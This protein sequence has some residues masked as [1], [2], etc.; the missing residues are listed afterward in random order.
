ML[1]SRRRHQLTKSIPCHGTMFH[2]REGNLAKEYLVE[3]GNEASISWGSP[4]CGYTLGNQVLLEDGL[5]R[6]KIISGETQR[7]YAG[8]IQRPN[9]TKNH[10][11]THDK[12]VAAKAAILLEL[13]TKDSQQMLR[14]KVTR[15][16]AV[17]NRSQN[18]LANDHGPTIT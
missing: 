1:D 7:V 17:Q 4:G 11:I 13:L 15:V 5:G 12:F 10:S 14:D 16:A 8:R 18:G 3:D 2:V 6:L 9:P